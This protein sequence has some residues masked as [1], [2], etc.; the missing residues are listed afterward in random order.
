MR[1]VLNVRINSE[2][3][4]KT[5][6]NKHTH[7]QK[8]G[9]YRA[10][11]IKPL[12]VFQFFCHPNINCKPESFLQKSLFS[13]APNP[14]FLSSARVERGCSCWIQYIL[15]LCTMDQ[16]AHAAFLSKRVSPLIW[17]S[18]CQ[19][20][21]G[22]GEVYWLS[23]PDFSSTELTIEGCR[24]N[25]KLETLSRDP[26]GGRFYLFERVLRC[27]SFAAPTVVT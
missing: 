20:N 22:A 23:T 1:D 9:K 27:L 8:H 24:S 11:K 21:W 26:E 7:T 25:F 5:K 2:E 16:L 18:S 15:L 13:Y 10:V 14:H 4:N 3:K 6:N 17:T 12:P 19:C